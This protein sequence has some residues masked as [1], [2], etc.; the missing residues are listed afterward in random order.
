MSSPHRILLVED[1]PLIVMMLEDALDEMGK[2]VVGSA[3]TVA[4]ALALIERDDFDAA[5][6]DLNLRGGETSWPVADALAALGKPFLLATGGA[7]D[8]VVPAHR[9]RPVVH[10]PFMMDAIARALDAL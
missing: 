7:G 1:E 3:D 6:L 4:G 8:T 2:S 10:K 5:I 9:H